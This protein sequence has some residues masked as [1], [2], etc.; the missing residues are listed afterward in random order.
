MGWADPV[1]PADRVARVV[2]AGPAGV[3]PAV[4]DTAAV[5]VAVATN[6]AAR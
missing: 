6:G 5:A 2:P 3:A 1:G 4:A